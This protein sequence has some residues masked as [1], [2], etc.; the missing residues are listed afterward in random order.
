MED[1]REG[2][3]P[4][5]FKIKLITK[6]L[7]KCSDLE[8]EETAVEASVLSKGGKDE[9]VKLLNILLARSQ[10]SREELELGRL[11]C[12]LFVKDILS[13][14]EN[15]FGIITGRNI[16]NM[17]FSKWIATVPFQSCLSNF[18]STRTSRVKPRL[19]SKVLKKI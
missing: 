13:K 19:S 12:F 3:C 8:K 14:V 15:R 1:E 4:V 5:S 2:I 11:L 7:T 17:S 18:H 9:E 6:V 16:R 10:K